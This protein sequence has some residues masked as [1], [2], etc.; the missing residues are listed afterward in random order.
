MKKLNLGQTVG[1]LANIG[2]I[3]GIVFLGIE[4]RQNNDLMRE[5]AERAR[6]ESIRE[7]STLVVENREL[8]EIL[9]KESEGDELTAV[10]GLQLEHYHLRALVGYS[11]SFRQLPTESLEAMANYFRRIYQASPAWRR[12][13]DQWGDT[14]EPDFIQFMEENIVNER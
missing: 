7:G 8:A 4:L 6:S 2:V 11:I 5:E 3:A 14:F 12:M 9:V 13:W 10:E 1:I